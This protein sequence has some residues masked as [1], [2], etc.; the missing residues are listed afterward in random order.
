MSTCP[1]PCQPSWCHPLCL[2]HP[3]TC[4]WALPLQRALDAVRGHLRKRQWLDEA[5]LYGQILSIQTKV[6]TRV[7]SHQP[8]VPSL[9]GKQGS[10]RGSGLA[11]APVHPHPL[12]PIDCTEE[13]NQEALTTQAGEAC[14]PLWLCVNEQCAFQKYLS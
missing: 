9:V 14:R 7:S 13:S 4:L 2:T 12:L 8:R 1:H 11:R 6:G 3:F 10:G 5:G